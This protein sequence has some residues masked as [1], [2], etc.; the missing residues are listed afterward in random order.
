MSRRLTLPTLLA[1]A[2]LTGPFGVVAQPTEHADPS[3]AAI[4]A[5]ARSVIGQARYATF[6]T[7]DERGAPQ[8]RIVDPFPPEDELTIWVATNGRTRKVGQIARDGRVTLTYFDREAQHYA[9]VAGTATLVRDLA[10]RAARWK[11]EWAP[12]YPNGYRGD[13]YLLIRIE[14]IRVEVVAPELGM[15]NDPTTW[16]PVTLELRTSSPGRR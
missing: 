4:L 11:A 12:F 1:I 13:D 15:K 7:L 3:R 2:A 8:S 6:T 9:T 10:A 14:P 16:R 5:A